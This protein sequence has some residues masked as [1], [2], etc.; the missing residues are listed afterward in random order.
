MIS[1]STTFIA[2]LRSLNLLSPP[3]PLLG[4][5]AS[6]T[7]NPFTGPDR[8]G[9]LTVHSP[10]DEP[11]P[12]PR[13]RRQARCRPLPIQFNQVCLTQLLFLRC[14]SALPV[15]RVRRTLQDI[16]GIN[17]C[18]FSP[19][20][21]NPILARLTSHR[22]FSQVGIRATSMEPRRE[23]GERVPTPILPPKNPTFAGTVLDR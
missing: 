3:S 19:P 1:L 14:L 2:K 21:S 5:K 17:Y 23:A 22:Y 12:P 4:K 18:L 20:R 11:L 7:K 10:F 16:R 13:A 8:V 9:Q 15:S 6:L